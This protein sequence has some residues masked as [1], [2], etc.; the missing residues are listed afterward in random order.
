[1]LEQKDKI[2][3]LCW[4]RDNDLHIKELLEAKGIKCTLGTGAEVAKKR[5]L[6]INKFKEDPDARVLI[7][8][9]GAIG[10]ALNLGYITDV[11]FAELHWT[12]TLNS[13]AVDRF[14]RLT[15]TQTVNIYYLIGKG[16]IEQHILEVTQRKNHIAEETLAIQ[17][18]IQA[19]LAI[20]A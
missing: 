18:V 5:I 9:I 10:T 8:T 14:H 12:P 19:L 17:S 4:N 16:T 6:T 2:A 3:I 15:S 7:G 13:Q 20:D 11:A 1:M